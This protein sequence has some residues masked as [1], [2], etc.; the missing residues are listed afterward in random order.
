[1]DQRTN[2][3][4]KEDEKNKVGEVEGRSHNRVWLSTK[5]LSMRGTK[6]QQEKEYPLWKMA[7][8]IYC[9]K[10]QILLKRKWICFSV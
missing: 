1:M 9:Q 10:R 3:D 2:L 5:F 4:V 8:V 6:V 7:K